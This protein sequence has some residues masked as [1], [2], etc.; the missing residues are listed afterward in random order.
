MRSTPNLSKPGDNLLLD[1]IRALADVSEG[2]DITATLPRSVVESTRASDYGFGAHPLGGYGVR[3][4]APDFLRDL[5][6]GTAGA[7]GNL[8]GRPTG[9]HTEALRPYSV[10][11]ASGM[12]VYAVPA[13]PQ[14][15]I[16]S[17]THP[18]SDIAAAFVGEGGTVPDLVTEADPAPAWNLEVYGSLAEFKTVGISVKMSRR[19]IKQGGPAA[20]ALIR[21]EVLAQIGRRIDWG[22]VSGDGV[23]ANLRGIVGTPG[24]STYTP[25]ER[26]P[27]F[28]SNKARFMS[29]DANYM[30]AMAL[31]AGCREDALSWVGGVGVRSKLGV[32]LA[33]LHDGDNDPITGP[34]PTDYYT[35]TRIPVWSGGM[36][37]GVPAAAT[38]DADPI[39]LVLGD[40]TR[41]FLLI[42]GFDV[43]M[44][45][46][47]DVSGAHRLT[48][49][50]DVALVLPQPKAFVV[51]TEIG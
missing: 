24:V 28:S 50:A 31:G 5:N 7:G 6:T 29:M 3:V 27:W 39:T 38:C 11:A 48:V 33:Y 16:P 8:V 20:D 37:C 40:W 15:L 46:R 51:C 36:L 41:A 10:T 22:V 35:P 19:I 30:V 14:P 49:L 1:V 2:G 18:T 42:Q 21:N 12:R 25:P 4:P 32:R 43:I 45:P 13:G 9:Y 17:I 44:D 47:F 34:W 26:T 23:G